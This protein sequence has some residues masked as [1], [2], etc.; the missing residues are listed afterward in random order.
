MRIVTAS[1]RFRARVSVA[2]VGV[3]TVEDGGG[4]F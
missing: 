2:L 1:C 3:V 4:G